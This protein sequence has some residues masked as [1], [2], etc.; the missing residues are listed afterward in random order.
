MAYGGNALNSLGMVKGQIM[1]NGGVI[2]SIAMSQAVFELFIVYNKTAVFDITED[3]SP[4]G[5][6]G[7]PYMHALFC[8]GWRDTPNGDGHWLCKNR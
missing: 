5:S 2:T 3:L 8:Y 6:A 7:A 4:S 1:L